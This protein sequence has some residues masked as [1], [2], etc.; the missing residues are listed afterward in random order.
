MAGLS[1]FF[2]ERL[3]R[4]WAL[5][6][7]R[8]RRKTKSRAME[9]DRSSSQKPP[10]KRPDNGQATFIPGNPSYLFPVRATNQIN[11][12]PRE[13]ICHLEPGRHPSAVLLAMTGDE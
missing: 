3:R 7:R 5:A 8:T 12:W 2:L 4:R 1:R 10:K 6:P 11:L 13:I 9:Q